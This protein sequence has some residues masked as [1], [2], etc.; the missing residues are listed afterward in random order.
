MNKVILIGRTTKEVVARQ[1]PNG[2]DIANFTLAVQRKF[3]NADGEYETDFINCVAWRKAAELIRDY[4]KK[5]DR[6]AVVG[7][8]Q[9]RNYEANDG[10]RR[11]VTE[12]VVNETHFVETK[13]TQNNNKN[14]VEKARMIEVD[15]IDG[16]SL[17]F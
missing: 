8:I 15:D 12:V 2:V 14:N 6:V 3:R 5:G 11:Y 9:T 1:T 4:V 10:T 13:G 7:E 16:D 17:P